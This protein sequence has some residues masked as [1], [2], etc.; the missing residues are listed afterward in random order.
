MPPAVGNAYS[1]GVA[2]EERVGAARKRARVE[3]KAA[4]RKEVRE[5]A[6]D[7][8]EVRALALA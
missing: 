3:E 6:A 5:T 4:D 2:A 7:R 1:Q 8:R